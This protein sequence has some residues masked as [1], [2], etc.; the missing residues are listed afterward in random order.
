MEIGYEWKPSI[1]FKANI[2]GFR[3]G[4]GLNGEKLIEWA[5]CPEHIL[6]TTEEMIHGASF[7][8]SWRSD[9]GCTIMHPEWVM[10]Q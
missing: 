10:G 5:D 3:K 4:I 2:W 1:Y 7:N 9:S 8:Y 6:L